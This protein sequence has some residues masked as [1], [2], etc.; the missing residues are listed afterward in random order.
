MANYDLAD[1]T[2][3]AQNP[4]SYPKQAFESAM[5]D[6]VSR[7]RELERGER[8]VNELRNFIRDEL[9]ARDY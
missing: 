7:I 3:L 9:D 2:R 1:M 5:R 8:L 4:R 6:A